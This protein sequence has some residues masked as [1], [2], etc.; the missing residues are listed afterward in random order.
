VTLYIALCG[1]VYHL[2]GF[3]AV[4]RESGIATLVDV[5]SHDS[6]PWITLTARL[7]SHYASF[8]II[9]MAGWIAIGSIVSQLIFVRTAAAIVIPFHLLLGFSLIGYALL[10]GSFFRKAQLSGVTALIISLAFAIVAQFVP[11]TFSAIVAIG[12]LFPP[13]TYTFFAIQLA[14]WEELLEGASLRSS[15]PY[16]SI[17]LPGYTF[18]IFLAAQIVVYPLLAAL[19]QWFL[20]VTSRSKFAASQDSDV[21]LRLS[22]VSKV[23]NN[24]WLSKLLP[25]NNRKVYAVNDL[26]LTIPRGQLFT[27]LGVNGSGKSTLLSGITRTYAFSSGNV[28]M[29]KGASIGFCPQSNVAWPDLTVLENVRIFSQLKTSRTTKADDGH[30]RELITACDI[31]HKLKAKPLSLSGGQQRKFQLA[32]AFVGGSIICCIDEASSGLDPL[33]RRK[34]WEILLRERGTKTIILTTHALDEADALCKHSI[35][36]RPLN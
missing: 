30:I 20:H 18:Y 5:M 33:S 11:R 22:G 9:Y 1:S 3:I 10:I 28:E 4:E 34:I 15:P 35:G 19:V 29:A 21:A 27:L 25:G 14:E 8:S 32:L 31:G 13:A 24:G 36:P 23:Y 6:R 12:L 7:A 17:S 26:S 16:G 2:A